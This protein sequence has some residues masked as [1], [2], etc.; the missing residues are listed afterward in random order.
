MPFLLVFPSLTF[1]FLLLI[2]FLSC[3]FS[4]SPGTEVMKDPGGLHHSPLPSPDHRPRAL[5]CVIIFKLLTDLS[6]F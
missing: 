3:L 2:E 1:F 5:Q 4:L 6:L